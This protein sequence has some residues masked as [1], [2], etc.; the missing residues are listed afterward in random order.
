MSARAR[1]QGSN[2]DLTGIDGPVRLLLERVAGPAASATPDLEAIGAAILDLAADLDYVMPWVRRLGDTAGSLP[3]PVP[4]RGPRLTLV[5]RP[6]RQMSA[7]H[8]HGTWVA[9]SP[10][11]GQETHR[12]YSV[13]G[14]GWTARPQLV[15]V[16]SLVAGDVLTLMPP[17]DTHDHG[18]MA[19]HG[20][21]AHV[22]ILTGDDQTRFARNEWDLA[23]G[24]HRVLGPG[25]SGRWLASEP[26]P[27]A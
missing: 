25:A 27:H 9:I 26:M 18:H 19:G 1:G 20:T 7:L 14:P 3:I 22:L 11:M 2:K 13:A 5:H 6:E 10:I 16:R 8:D 24:R 21:P 23:T 17:N 4:A 12:R 15:E